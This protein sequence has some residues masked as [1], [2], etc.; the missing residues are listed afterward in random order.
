MTY[1]TLLVE[2]AVG[3]PNHNVLNATAEL[4]RRFQS[5]V[6]GI[7]AAQPMQLAYGDGYYSG[8]AVQDDRDELTRELSAAEAEFRSAFSGTAF[9]GSAVSPGWHAATIYQTNADFVSQ[10]AR[11]AD[12]IITAG[13]I[14]T[15]PPST[16]SANTGDLLMQAGRPVLLLPRGFA[17]FSVAHALVAWKDTRETRRA[18]A[19]AL[20]LLKIAEHVVLAQFVLTDV[21]DEA[22]TELESVSRWLR[23]HGVQAESI[24]NPSVG[25]D[26]T[27][28]SALIEEKNADL[29]VAGAYGHSRLTEWVLGGVTR[30][31]LLHAS[32]CSLLSH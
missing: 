16:R 4:A 25:E 29:V 26:P 21:M 15:H 30:D 14:S 8:E 24:T 18:I 28:L 27:S 23:S 19:D 32:H 3:E 13:G 22:R 12:L 11:E 5:E 31:L 10:H 6:I 17:R 9:S 20:P 7:A 2:L 1:K